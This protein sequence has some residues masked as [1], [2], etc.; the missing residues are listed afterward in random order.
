MPRNTTGGSNHKKS[1]NHKK[2][3]KREFLTKTDGQE[4]AQV[5]KMLGNGRITVFCFDGRE[6]LGIIRGNMRKRVWVNQDDIILV[7]LRSFQDDKA[8]VLHKY[9][10]E[11]ITRLRKM[12]YLPNKV[13]V[14]EDAKDGFSFDENIQEEDELV[15]PTRD[16]PSEE[17]EDKDGSFSSEVDLESLVG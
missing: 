14:D 9:T 2:E 16:M 4:Y 12:G 8:D 17:S 1:A 10:N 15:Q 13:K 3:F 11:E 7:G 6:R 5:L